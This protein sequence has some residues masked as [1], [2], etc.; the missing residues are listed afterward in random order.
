MVA[1]PKFSFSHHSI[2]SYHQSLV[3][4]FKSRAPLCVEIERTSVLAV[5]TGDLDGAFL[6][7][8]SWSAPFKTNF[9]RAPSKCPET[10]GV[11]FPA[12]ARAR[13]RIYFVFLSDRTRLKFRIK[14]RISR[15][16]LAIREPHQN[17]FSPR[18][19]SPVSPAAS[20]LAAVPANLAH[21]ERVE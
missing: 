3:N 2:V 8:A 21:G 6:L 12:R 19:P 17:S 14:W 20:A 7:V 10:R 1:A 13:V 16:L 5:F 4:S 11:A 9:W 18:S 15:V